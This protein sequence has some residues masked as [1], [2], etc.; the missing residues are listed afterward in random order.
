MD[1][2]QVI[3]YYIFK[4]Y[5]Y[6]EERAYS[7]LLKRETDR[8]HAIKSHCQIHLDINYNSK[9]EVKPK[10]LLENCIYLFIFGWKKQMEL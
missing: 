10:A 9:V 7:V 2:S 3:F 1:F 8:I 5:Y 6:R 4:S